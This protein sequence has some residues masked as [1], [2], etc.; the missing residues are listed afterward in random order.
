MFCFLL[1]NSTLGA[2]TALLIFSSISCRKLSTLS[3][4]SSKFST[5]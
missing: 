1:E 5:N 4:F 2:S 3:R